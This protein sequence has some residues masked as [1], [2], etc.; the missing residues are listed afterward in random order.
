[1]FWRRR[2]T[3]V[4]SLF[5][6]MTHA[7]ARFAPGIYKSLRCEKQ[8]DKEKHRNDDFVNTEIV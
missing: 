7:L 2:N 8:N 5:A 4:K 3:F 6:E 1:M